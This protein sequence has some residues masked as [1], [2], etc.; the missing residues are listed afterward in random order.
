MCI[1]DRDVAAHPSAR[2]ARGVAPARG[3]RG[4]AA[5]PARQGTGGLRRAARARAGAAAGVGGGLGAAGLRRDGTVAVGRGRLG[6]GRPSGVRGTGAGSAGTQRCR[7]R[8]RLLASGVV[9]G[10]STGRVSV[11]GAAVPAGDATRPARHA[12]RERAGRTVRSAAQRAA[13]AAGGRRRPTG[14]PLRLPAG[15]GDRAAVPADGRRGGA[16]VQ[17]LLRVRGA[18]VRAQRAELP[19]AGRGVSAGRRAAG[20]AP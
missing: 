4:V 11:R 9:R 18:E 14:R 8:P 12:G 15:S 5:V 13:A 1:R 2:P 3:P 6:A 16:A 20:R 7:A 19:R 10:T 17:A